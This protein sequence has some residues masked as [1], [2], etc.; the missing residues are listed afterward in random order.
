MD[1]D[2]ITIQCI[3]ERCNTGKSITIHFIAVKYWYQWTMCCW[4]ILYWTTYYRYWSMYYWKMYNWIMRYWI[5]SGPCLHV[6]KSGYAQLKHK[7]GKKQW[8]FCCSSFL[9]HTVRL[10]IRSQNHSQLTENSGRPL[11]PTRAEFFAN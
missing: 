8:L 5:F 6:T 4:T 9:I 10:A 2:C 11:L 7:N 1:I 3:T